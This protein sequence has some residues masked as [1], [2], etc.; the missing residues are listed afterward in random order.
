L[1]RETLTY[2]GQIQRFA[3]AV[4]VDIP[5]AIARL[6][7]VIAKLEDYVAFHPGAEGEAAATEG[8]LIGEEGLPSMA[9]PEPAPI[10]C[11]PLEAPG[12]DEPKPP[13]EEPGKPAASQVRQPL[14][15]ED[16]GTQTDRFHGMDRS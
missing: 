3:T 14:T 8:F 11:P 16:Q 10:Q 9:R 6:D 15:D 1:Q 7:A 4:A 2:R 13:G 12:T 5:L